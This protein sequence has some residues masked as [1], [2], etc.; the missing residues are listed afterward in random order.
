MFGSEAREVVD[1]LVLKLKD[2]D[3][4]PLPMYVRTML[5]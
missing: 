1:N 4:L 3:A 2:P 5:E